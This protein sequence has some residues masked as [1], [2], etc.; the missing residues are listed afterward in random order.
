[1]SLIFLYNSSVQK[2]VNFIDLFKEAVF[3]LINFYYYLPV[4][5]FLSVCSLYM[6][7]QSSLF[8]FFCLL[9]FYWLFY[10]FFTFLKVDAKLTDTKPFL[11]HIRYHVFPLI[12]YSSRSHTLWYV[13]GFFNCCFILFSR[14]R[15]QPSMYYNL[16]LVTLRVHVCVCVCVCFIHTHTEDLECELIPC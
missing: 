8:P 5:Y 15:Y 1:M 12:Y 16:V 10:F 4:F 6:G 3:G 11:L 13:S 2:L 9:W 14:Q 7:W